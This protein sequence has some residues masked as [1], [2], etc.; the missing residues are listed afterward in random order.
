MAHQDWNV[1]ELASLLED[2]KVSHAEINIQD[3]T[4]LVSSE[5]CLVAISTLDDE[6][7]C[8]DFSTQMPQKL[9]SYTAL[10]VGVSAGTAVLLAVVIVLVACLFIFYRYVWH[11]RI[12]ASTPY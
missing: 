10:F 1:T 12:S 4:L 7:E 6:Q 5:A 8:S 2:W 3:E 11:Q 9:L